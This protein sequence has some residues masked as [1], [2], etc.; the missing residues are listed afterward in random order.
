MLHLQDASGGR[1]ST[2]FDQPAAGPFPRGLHWV[3]RQGGSSSGVLCPGALLTFCYLKYCLL[4]V[5]QMVTVFYFTP[6]R[7]KNMESTGSESFVEFDICRL[8][9]SV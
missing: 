6:A 2:E 5:A 7:I 3:G 1:H 9:L 4:H 8:F